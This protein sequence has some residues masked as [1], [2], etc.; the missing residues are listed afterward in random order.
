MSQVAITLTMSESNAQRVLD[1]WG[2]DPGGAETP[3]A[4]GKR[5]IREHL[6]DVVRSAE[7][8]VA[9]NTARETA[10]AAADVEIT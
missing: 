1:A 9:A 6:I 10:L 8:S 3:A 7:A 2:Y 5:K 4:F